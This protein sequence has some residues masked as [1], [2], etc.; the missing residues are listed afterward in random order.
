[1]ALAS[2][3]GPMLAGL[4]YDRAGGYEPFLLAGTIGCA[5]GGVLIVS[6]PAY[7]EWGKAEEEPAPVSA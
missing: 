3:V 4:V 7:P 5:L 1:M 2:G 6:L